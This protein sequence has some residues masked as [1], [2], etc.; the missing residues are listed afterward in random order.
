MKLQDQVCTLAQAKRLKELRVIGG[1]F[2]FYGDEYRPYELE[3]TGEPEAMAGYEWEETY[4]A[5]T[6]AELGVM[7]GNHLSGITVVHS[8]AH[9]AIGN[10]ILNGGGAEGTEAQAR[11]ALL[12]H[13]LE[14]GEISVSE[15][16]K[17]IGS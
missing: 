4:P 17:R 3:W 10:A 7:L 6:V 14:T 13:L 15:V 5:F 2:T 8:N 11:A 1:L 12:I 9:E 16:N